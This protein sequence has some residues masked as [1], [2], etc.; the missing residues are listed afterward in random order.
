[1]KNYYFKIAF[2][3]QPTLKTKFGNY[4]VK[5]D[6]PL[7]AEEAIKS[8]TNG[9]RYIIEEKQ[10]TPRAYRVKDIWLMIELCFGE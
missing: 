5:F 10:N 8:K 3:D 7:E 9:W 2:C 4:Y 6:S 1:M